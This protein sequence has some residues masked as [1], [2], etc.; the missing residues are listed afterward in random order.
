MM[1]VFFSGHIEAAVDDS[2]VKIAWGYKGHTG[3]EF[4]GRLSPHFLLCGEGTSQSPIN[5]S[6]NDVEVANTLT[7]HYQT[8]PLIIVDDGDTS[9]MIGNK[10]IIFN[11][12][13]TIQINFHGNSNKEFISYQGNKYQLKQ[14]HFHSPSENQLNGDSA[15]LEIHFVHQGEKGKVVV[16]GV[17]VKGGSANP[18][19]QTIIDHLPMADGKE[20]VV[21]GVK[22]NPKDIFPLDNDYYSFSGSLTTPPC[23]EGLQWIV[24]A[25]TIN[26]SPAQ[27]AT[28]RKAL[29]GSNARAVQ[30]LNNRVIAYSLGKAS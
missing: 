15:P 17:L 23:T 22:I 13:H 4:W 29:G 28:I 14:F 30:P 7:L 2:S 12:G 11:D 20:H 5:I 3:P 24:M 27:I 21:A 25:G 26:A 1:S 8:A 19:L 10:Q 9:L 16:I 6:K 18:E